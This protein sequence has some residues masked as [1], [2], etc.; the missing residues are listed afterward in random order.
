MLDKKIL[1]LCHWNGR[2]GNRIHQY[3]YG[4][5][6]QKINGHEFY[7]PSDW[8]GTKLFKNQ[9]HKI[10]EDDLL[11]LELNQ[12]QKV[13]DN[14]HFRTYALKKFSSKMERIKSDDREPKDDPYKVFSDHMFV[15]NVSAY[16][17]KIFYPMSLKEIKNVFE[18]SDEIKSLDVYKRN[19]DRQ[20]TYDIAHLRRDDI[21]NPAY[22][23]KNHQG[24]SVVSKDSYF[25]CFEKFDFNPEKIEWVSDDYIGT[26][27][28][29]RP[30]AI[31]AGW[32]YPRG[33]DFLDKIGFDWLDDFLKLYFA[34][35]IF[36]ANSSF[37]WWAAC[38]S[39][40]AK[41]Y[42]PVIDKQIIYGVDAVEEIEVDFVEGNQ[43]H[44]MYDCQDI[45]LK[46]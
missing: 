44:W 19:E 21:S 2:F 6:Y 36:R 25:R 35:S 7:L 22:N 16:N 20:G 15:D 34:R 31:R 14:I 5:Y 4:Y 18:L 42:S 17:P 27:H 23:K 33:S 3:I 32:T 11:R 41:I 45:V 28:K 9:Y 43:P 29:D 24:Y 37:S 12:N 46:E 13:L 26:W 8:E 1:L 10:I 38:L 30:K 40:V 39:P